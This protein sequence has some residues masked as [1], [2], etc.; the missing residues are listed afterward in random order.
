MATVAGGAWHLLEDA[1]WLTSSC[2]DD[3]D[4]GFLQEVSVFP[5]GKRDDRVDCLSQCHNH[6]ADE[7]GESMANWVG[8]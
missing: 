8:W 3:D 4:R 6:F 2:G 7:S 5:N 1:A